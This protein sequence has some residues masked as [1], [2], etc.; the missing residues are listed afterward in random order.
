[1]L[2]ALTSQLSPTLKH[3]KTVTVKLV[4]LPLLGNIAFTQC[5]LDDWGACAYFVISF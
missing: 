3:S 4:V 1:M 5:H 2:N